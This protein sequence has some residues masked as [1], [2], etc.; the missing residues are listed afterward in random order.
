MHIEFNFGLPSDPHPFFEWGSIA[1]G[2][3]WIALLGY[4]LKLFWDYLH[5]VER[6]VSI[7]DAL[8][9]ELEL[10][11]KNCAPYVDM[12][13][14]NRELIEAAVRADS[15][16]FPYLPIGTLRNI[17]FDLYK[18]ELEFLSRDTTK[19]VFDTYLLDDLLYGCVVDFRS[20]EFIALKEQRKLSAVHNT[21]EVAQKLDG[22]VSE[23][24]KMLEQDRAIHNHLEWLRLKLRIAARE[25]TISAAKSD[26]ERR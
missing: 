17:A 5:T 4:G 12:L 26:D 6:R 3:L 7:V 20:K 14:K 11:Q 13:G 19:A 25:P 21:A 24:L 18:P 16:Y 1:L 9:A 8:V 2:P 10:T 23:T 22:Q 15:G